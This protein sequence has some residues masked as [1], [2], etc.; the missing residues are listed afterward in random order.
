V[1]E[2][3]ETT[4]QE[5]KKIGTDSVLDWH[6]VMCRDDLIPPFCV[7]VVL[8][9]GAR[10]SLHSVLEFDDQT[11]SICFRIWDLR[12]LSQADVSALKQKLNDIRERKELAPAERLHPK[13]DWA[14]GHA[15]YD[16]VSYCVE[17]HDRIWP[18]E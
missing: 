14:N 17:W 9:D 3:S 5:P 10:Y 11:R 16:D 6:K 18:K 15:H 13:L 7:E 12:A 1:E 2:L 4:S 8:R